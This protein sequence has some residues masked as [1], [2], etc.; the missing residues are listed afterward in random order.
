M[1]T[2][3][4]SFKDKPIA[5]QIWLIIGLVLGL[6]AVVFS[7]VMPII[8]R[9][10]ITKERYNRVEENQ[11]FLLSNF[12]YP[13]IDQSFSPPSKINSEEFRN[14]ESGPPIEFS[15]IIR[16]FYLE[17][18]TN[19]I[20][21]NFDQEVL[22]GIKEKAF[23]QEKKLKSYTY[24]LSDS[25]IIY[26]LVRKISNNEREG[27]LIS[28]VHTYYRDTLFQEVFNGMMHSLL[29]VLFLSWIASIFVAKYLTKSL[30]FLNKEVKK[31]AKNEW[32]NPIIVDRDD[33]IGEVAQNIEWMRKQ[34]LIRDKNQQNFLQEVSHEI[35][36]PIMVLRGYIQSM[37]DGIYPKGDLDGTLEAMEEESFKMEKRLKSL[38]NITK[39]D[40]ISRKNLNKETFSLD[41]CLKQKMERLSWRRKDINWTI[42]SSDLDYY[43]DH[44]KLAVAL[45]NI[46]DNQFK[47][48]SSIIKVEMEEK[49]NNLKTDSKKSVLIKFWNDGPKIEAEDIG[50]IFDKFNKGESG[51][52]GLGLSITKIIIE[53]HSGKIW[54]VNE[55]DGVSFYVELPLKE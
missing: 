2:K 50:N 10:K 24:E 7:I 55:D 47:F 16:H 32:N 1:I 15:R 33:E 46:I 19:K 29:I 54:A 25:Q 26:Y 48:S 11:E 12:E 18:A 3:I 31:I 28:Y 36:T 8:I 27:Y 35:K 22:T 49:N 51:E 37:Q 23:Q 39:M 41:Q 53:A 14:K 5:F 45:E 13:Y 30:R 17:T 43:G 6:S 52:Y 38:I 9:D 44:E 20:V 34:L 21:G 42:T 40:F 4:F